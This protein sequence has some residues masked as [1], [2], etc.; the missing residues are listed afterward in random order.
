MKHGNGCA[1]LEYVESVMHTTS[2]SRERAHNHWHGDAGQGSSG[3]GLAI[4]RQGHFDH[5]GC[6]PVNESA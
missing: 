3:L 6:Q 2:R 4:C 1:A 5:P